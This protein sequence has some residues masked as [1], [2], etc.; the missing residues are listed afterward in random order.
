MVYHPRSTF[1]TAYDK[2]F[3][4]AVSKRLRELR[5]AQG[6]T[7]EQVAESIGMT[8]YQ[9]S[10]WERGH[11]VVHENTLPKLLELYDCTWEDFWLGVNTKQPIALFKDWDNGP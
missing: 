6:L 4:K 5:H 10:R 3:A 2:H 9:V 8:N 11:I 1:R 7:Q